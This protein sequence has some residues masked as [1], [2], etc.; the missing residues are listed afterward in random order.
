MASLSFARAVRVQRTTTVEVSA[1]KSAERWRYR[2][3]F[4]CCDRN[5]E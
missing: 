2:R 3:S 4:D 1:P 5:G